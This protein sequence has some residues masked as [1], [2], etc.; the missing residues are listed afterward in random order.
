MLSTNSQ[1]NLSKITLSLSPKDNIDL[2]HIF[3]CPVS[4]REID[5]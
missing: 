1:Y 4:N 5:E 2:Y 3:V